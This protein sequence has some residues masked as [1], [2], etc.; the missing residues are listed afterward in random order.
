MNLSFREIVEIL[1]IDAP[2]HFTP[3]EQLDKTDYVFCRYMG[4]AERDAIM[5]GNYNPDTRYDDDDIG[6]HFP[7]ISVDEYYELET[8]RNPVAIHSHICDISSKMVV[9]VSEFPVFFSV[10][11]ALHEYGHWIY[12]LNSGM[13]AYEFCMAETQVRKPYEKMAQDIYNI[14][15]WAPHKTALAKKYEEIYSHFPSEAAANQYAM[16]HIVEAI[17]KIHSYLEG[18]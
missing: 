6:L 13:S 12:F 2:I 18:K 11:C 3:R 9:P 7:D 5:T 1:D 8:V 14:P 17:A 16:N 15:D 10:H 4:N